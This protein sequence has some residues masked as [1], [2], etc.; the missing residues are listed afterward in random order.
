MH[1]LIGFEPTFPS[2][3]IESELQKRKS[4]ISV[5]FSLRN[6]DDIKG[7]QSESFNH[8][9][10]KSV[11]RAHQ[12]WKTTCFEFFLNPKG[13]KCYYEFNFSLQPAWNCYYFENYRT[14]AAP[15]ESF[16][17]L[18]M[19]FAWNRRSQQIHIVL[20][21]RTDTSHFQVGLT[22]VIEGV[23]G[24]KGYFALKHCNDKPD[25]HDSNSFILERK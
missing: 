3:I 9:Q 5:Q 7:L 10:L 2:L 17:F 21:N 25:F 19:E 24:S 13:S 22:A 12:L 16:D 1:K 4:E 11:P 20:E 14:P 15:Q 23:T 8:D 6:A 18:L